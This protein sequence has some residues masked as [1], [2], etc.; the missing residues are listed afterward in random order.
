MKLISLFIEKP[1]LANLITI[2]VIVAGVV[3]L[4]QLN[5]STY[6][7]VNFDVLTITT[8]YPG[9]SAKEIEVQIT[10]KIEDSIIGIEGLD[11]IVSVSAENYSSV[12]IWIDL[13][14][15]YPEK[16]KNKINRAI[17][18][19]SDLPSGVLG[20][21]KVEELAASNMP[22]IEVALQ[23]NV[24][25]L[26]LRKI[27][28]D[29]KDKLKSLSGVST[30][31][32]IGYRKRE[33]KILADAQQLSEKWISLSDIIYAIKS[34]NLNLPGGNL[35]ELG[36]SKKVV[37]K[38]E[39]NNPLDI[40]KLIIRSNDSG[41]RVYLN[42]VAEIRDEFET[43]KIISR[44][45]QESSIN[46]V[47]K[48]S[49][50]A[51]VVEIS[52]EIE[53]ILSAVRSNSNGKYRVKVVRNFAQYII[54]LLDI[55]TNNAYIGFALVLLSLMIFL[56][57]Y[58]AFWTALGIP[59]SILGAL[60]FFPM[61]GINI[62]FIPLITMILVLGLIV[63][64]AIVVAENICRHREM[65]KDI[66][67]AALDGT[68]E[69]CWP[70]ITTILTTILAFAPI[71]FMSGVTG[72]FIQEI[73][74]IVILTL[75]FSLFES[76]LILPSHIAHGPKIKPESNKLFDKLKK[77][78]GNIITWVL[79]FRGKALLLFA[80]FLIGSMSL[81]VFKMRFVLFPYSDVDIFYVIA[82]M[83]E[84]TS[85]QQM[86][87]KMKEVE[88]IVPLIPEDELVSYTTRIGHHNINVYTSESASLKDNWALTTVYLKQAEDRVRTSEEI[89]QEF[90]TKLR[91]KVH[92]F[93]RL[94]VMKYYDGP[95][96]GRPITLTL[97]SDNQGLR[98]KYQNKVV[99]YLSKIPGVTNLE[100][101]AI[102]GKEEIMVRPIFNKMTRLGI[103][104]AQLSQVIRSA[105]EGVVATSITREGENIDFRVKLDDRFSEG[106]EL[107]MNLEVPNNRGQLIKLKTFVE[108][109]K[110]K[111]ENKVLHYNGARSITILGDVDDKITTS[112][113]V[114]Q[115]IKEKFMSEI[116]SHTGISL[117]FGGEEK[118]T[119]ESMK[120]LGIA[121][122][123]SFIAIYFILSVLFNSV[124]QPF[125]ILSVVPF[126][127]CGVIISFFFHGMPISFFAMIGSM[128]LM[129]IL[130]NDSLVMVSHLNRVIDQN[131]LD[132]KTIVKGA[133]DRFRAVILTTVSTV[134]GMIPT[135]Y[136]FGGEQ[137]FLI[138]L[139]LS[140]A[141]GLIFGTTLTLILVPLLYSFKV[142]D[143]K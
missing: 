22:V 122:S 4:S 62:N 44:T 123:I 91:S 58:A 112:A 95:P 38:S 124:W 2:L 3:S 49:S 33:V 26:E 105:F 19:I 30:V 54:S 12:I 132:L 43:P 92:G 100:V 113:Q 134:A 1:L 47:V 48:S 64:D 15:K 136:G 142:K 94:D 102:P 101:D 129:G 83:P 16:A 97:V 45:E 7:D 111:S 73:P 96:I 51:D 57:R 80:A 56:N 110:S 72:R 138:P 76:L 79:R 118:A 86:S 41:K 104:S 114:N 8:T 52:E 135:I 61:L 59:L 23:G 143:L 120:S 103:T 125:L 81:F 14:Y 25:E 36:I 37:T 107:L 11:K 128:G 60:I 66:K 69:V 6:P 89:I 74:K 13:N 90:E 82:E 84:G 116:E 85:I 46:L 20:T 35:K 31:D 63:D 71:F 32:L 53:K 24:S 93:S 68:K 109:L 28:K 87:T 108:I 78:Y 106:T 34:Q 75:V 77:R 130:V 141:G 55:V 117:V 21:P 127:L 70:V 67:Q 137:P 39:I 40:S 126:G 140:I 115:K 99:N 139:V 42:D 50:N 98:N 121:F 10:N 133:E 29:L 27:A 18:R 9:A 65:G 88:Q 119:Q 17:D 131:N 5:K